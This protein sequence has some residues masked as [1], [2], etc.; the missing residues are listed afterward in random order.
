MPNSRVLTAWQRAG[1]GALTGRGGIF[2]PAWQA[3]DAALPSLGCIRGNGPASIL[4]EGEDRCAGH[5]PFWHPHQR[6]LA[7]PFPA[8]AFQKGLALERHAQSIV[9]HVTP[10]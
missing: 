10:P 2:Y 1:S 5:Y 3:S 8:F 7:S 9:S 6:R 4:C